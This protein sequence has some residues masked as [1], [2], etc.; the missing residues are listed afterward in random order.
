[1]DAWSRSTSTAKC[2]E[3]RIALDLIAPYDA[4]MRHSTQPRSHHRAVLAILAV[5]LGLFAIGCPQTYGPSPQPQP[6]VSPGPV[7][8]PVSNTPAPDGSS[9]NSFLEC[10]SGICE[11]QGCGPNEGVCASN[12]RRCTRDMATMCG[13][14]GV[15]FQGSSSCPGKRFARGGA[16][17]TSGGEATN[18]PD[19]S[20]CTNPEDCG[21]GICEGM[22]CGTEEGVCAPKSRPC[23]RDLRSYCGCDGQTFQSSGSCPGA[24]FSAKGTCEAGGGNSNRVNLSV[25]DRCGAA[26][27]CA[28]G[29]CEGQGC[30]PL[31][32]VCA[33]KMRAC[34]M[35]IRQYCGCDG[36]TFQS[37]GSCAGQLYAKRG[38]C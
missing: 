2:R 5:A 24:R 25:G 6:G 17:E 21:S 29:I 12:E 4:R 1:M 15:T 35:D 7:G 33:D 20:A 34:T 26:S 32:G 13:C 8:Q 10:D 14:D 18:R 16:C 37:S 31:A 38:P 36:Q 28:S 30:G 19:G 3:G 22:G 23:T 27:E 11:G 9:C